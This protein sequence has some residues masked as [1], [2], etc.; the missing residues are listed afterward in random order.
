MGL[1]RRDRSYSRPF[2]RTGGIFAPESPEI[3]RR[4]VLKASALLAALAT[5]TVFGGGRVVSH[6]AAQESAP[7]SSFEWVESDYIS[8]DLIGTGN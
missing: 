7:V 2:G 5:G 1:A 6:A 4:V 8:A 3:S